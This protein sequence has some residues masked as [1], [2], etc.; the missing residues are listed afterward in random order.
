MF[1][2]KKRGNGGFTLIEMLIVVVIV[3]V[4]V[5]MAVPRFVGVANEARTRQCA[6]NIRALDSAI[7]LYNSREN[8][9]PD[10]LGDVTGD[11]NYFPDG[12]P[13]CPYGVDYVGDGEAVDDDGNPVGTVVG[14][15]R[16][17]H[18]STGNWPHTHDAN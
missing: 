12:A 1:K 4:L 3:G 11:T 14:V 10:E 6:G 5:A 9:Y 18:F 7:E 13:V 15:L 8:G 2:F 17:D 16:T